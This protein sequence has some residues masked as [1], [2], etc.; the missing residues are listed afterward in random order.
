MFNL[1]P[2]A[3]AKGEATRRR[4]L[5]SALALFRR[6]GYA[7]TTMRDIAEAAGMSLGAAYHFFPSKD[8]LVVAYYEWMQREHERLADAAGSPDFDL[9]ARLSVLLG[10][11]LGLLARD[12][13]LL[14]AFF[15][16]LGD[17]AQPLSIFSRERA[18]L[19]ER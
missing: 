13:K 18:D 4:I 5:A 12:R 11:K 16:N 6:R 15:A 8:A 7:Q 19:R 3:S 10:T 1:D 17:P 2:G 9:E 14:A